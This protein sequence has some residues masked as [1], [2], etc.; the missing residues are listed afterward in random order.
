[1]MMK[2]G[3]C[4]QPVSKGR[5]REP[6]LHIKQVPT[7]WPGHPCLPEDMDWG[8]SLSRAASKPACRLA[9]N[10]CGMAKGASLAYPKSMLHRTN[11]PIQKQSLCTQRSAQMPVNC[12]ALG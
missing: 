1:M 8:A 5:E 3:T 9:T 2:V 4:Q 7:V 12:A 6:S 11:K 10:S